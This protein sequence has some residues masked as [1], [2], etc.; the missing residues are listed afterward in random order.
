[1]GFRVLKVINEDRVEAGGG[2]GTHGHRDMEI[3]TCII[4]G[5]LEH[6]DSLG[7]G[8][9]IRPGDVQRMSAGTGVM[10]SEFNASKTTSVHFLQVWIVPDHQGLAPG[11]EQKSFPAAER[12]GRLRLVASPDGSD[13]SVRINQDARLYMSVLPAGQSVTHEPGADR[14]AWLQVVRGTLQI[15]AGGPATPLGAGD[16]AA[17]G[18]ERKVTIHAAD[19]SEFLLFDLP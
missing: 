7:T 11:Y 18:R 3:I 12:T 15:Q 2:F 10:H 8:S 5:A 13:G 17:I 16:G 14:H 6:K 1:M 4:D 9:V 19:A